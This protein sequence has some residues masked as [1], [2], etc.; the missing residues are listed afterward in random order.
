MS[1]PDPSTESDRDDDGAGPPGAL[2]SPAGMP[3]PNDLH[4][5]VR[6]NSEVL[7]CIHDA[8]TRLAKALER[9][10]RTEMVLK[11]TDA[12]NQTFRRLHESQK[13][14]ADRLREERRRG[15]YTMALFGGL[16]AAVVV[17]I[18]Y[19]VIGR[20][21][22]EL[23]TEAR[24]LHESRRE[25]L[26][27]SAR[28]QVELDRDRERMFDSVEQGFAANRVLANEN[29]AQAAEIA[30]LKQILAATQGDLREQ[31][32]TGTGD[33]AR[34]QELEEKSLRLER[35]LDLA[36]EQLVEH[37]LRASELES[38]VRSLEGTAVPAAAII[39]A[40]ADASSPR[41]DRAVETDA[42]EADAAESGAGATV[43]ATP[44]GAE[45]TEAWIEPSHPSSTASAASTA[46]APADPNQDVVDAVNR[47]LRDAG[48]LD[49]RLLR[50]E[51]IEAGRVV[52]PLVEVR[53][54]EG[55]PIGFHDAARGSFE[56]DVAARSGALVLED[57]FSVMRG[58]RA[59]FAGG[60][61]V[62]II[63]AVLAGSWNVGPMAAVTRE[64]ASDAAPSPVAAGSAA[65]P[66]SLAASA[67]VD[68]DDLR[69]RINAL[70]HA[71][72]E[73][74]YELSRLDGV[75][76]GRLVG[77]GLHHYESSGAL[78]KT[79]TAKWLDIEIEGGDR[80]VRL[81]FIE[82]YHVARGRE[83]PFFQGRGDDRPTWTLTLGRGDAS[84]WSAL[85]ADLA[86]A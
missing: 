65:E 41:P 36:R 76:A 20:L 77:V 5:Q 61:L 78:K 40:M 26:A 16:G 13:V 59:P 70:L 7:R 17:A 21:E 27:R 48:V 39:E 51:G 46:S 84:R 6:M 8:H 32:H 14:L 58:A 33:L 28:S 31:R 44:A 62:T 24:A 49:L 73:R 60:R 29:K 53:S 2:E 37:D 56:V 83:V 22:G 18:A 35:E 66:G 12:L 54:A 11:S 71:D 50:C 3:A 63:P 30:R 47:F 9:S 69:G 75:E 52:R 81:R 67:R 1:R 19:V 23:R 82:G 80:T 43:A 86:D 79:V 34:Q 68:L 57:G 38:L 74:R 64:I 85:V 10:D 25:D 42:A 45:P 55:F 15:P 72:G 4:A